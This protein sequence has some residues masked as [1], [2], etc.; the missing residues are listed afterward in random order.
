MW[1]IRELALISLYGYTILLMEENL[2]YLFSSS[3][4][5][6]CCA[7]SSLLLFIVLST[8]K[9]EFQVEMMSNWIWNKMICNSS[10]FLNKIKDLNRIQSLFLGLCFDLNGLDFAYFQMKELRQV[11]LAWQ[12]MFQQLKLLFLLQT[13]LWISQLITSVIRIHLM[14]W[15]AVLTGMQN[16]QGYLWRYIEEQY[17]CHC[18]SCDFLSYSIMPNW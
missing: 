12:T 3:R 10:S 9:L 11:H 16:Y 5:V 14:K 1:L 4:S 8:R 15:R 18:W 13:N 7:C 17:Y 6:F 2:Q